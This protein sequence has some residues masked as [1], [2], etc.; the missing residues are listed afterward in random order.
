MFIDE[1]DATF[2]EPVEFDLD[3]PAVRAAIA[4]RFYSDHF[5]RVDARPVWA[6]PGRRFYR[7]NWWR[8]R[9]DSGQ[10]YIAESAFVR[11]DETLAG[12]VVEEAPRRGA[13]VSQAALDRA[14]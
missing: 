13:A 1:T 10:A 12:Y 6:R 3:G 8:T 7:V 5:G 2:A 4:A 11:V 9:P 14:A